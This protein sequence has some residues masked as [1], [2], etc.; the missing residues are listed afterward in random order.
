MEPSDELKE[1]CLDKYFFVETHFIPACYLYDI[2]ITRSAYYTLNGNLGKALQALLCQH[3]EDEKFKG[4][5]LGRFT[6]I[7]LAAQREVMIQCDLFYDMTTYKGG[8][9]AIMR[10]RWFKKAVLERL[11]PIRNLNGVIEQWR[12]EFSTSDIELVD[13]EGGLEQLSKC[14]CFMRR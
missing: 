5:V 4:T 13:R 12:V 9:D 7:I 2:M 3:L 1:A 14:F 8:Y 11:N 6:H 10:G